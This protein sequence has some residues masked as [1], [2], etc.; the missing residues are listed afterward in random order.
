MKRPSSA[1]QH[2]GEELGRKLVVLFF[3]G[4]GGNGQRTVPQQDKE[5]TL[6]LISTS[7]SP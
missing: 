2:L 6:P 4:L 1:E 5:F 3:G 7:V